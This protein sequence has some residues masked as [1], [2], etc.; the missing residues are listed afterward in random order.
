MLRIQPAQKNVRSMRP[1]I[2]LALAGGGPLGAIYELGAL[3]AL[4]D[5][6]IGLDLTRLDAYVGV[7]AGSFIAA[8]L[9]NN[10]SPGDMCRLF[11]ADDGH[12]RPDVFLRPAYAEY[13]RSASRLPRVLARSAL[14][15][16][17][18][19]LQL[20]LSAQLAHYGK[21]VPPGIFDNDRI[22]RFLHEAFSQVGRSDHFEEL[23]RK[24]FIVA[25][26]LD[27]GKAVRFGSEEFRDIPISRA[28]QASAALPGLYPPVEYRGRQYVDGA[29][30]RTM[31]ASVALDE[32]VSLLIG[33]NPLVPFS[34]EGGVRSLASR[35]LPTVL[36]QTFRAMIHSRMQIGVESYQA[37]YPAADL[38]L[39]EPDRSD[40]RLFFANVFSYSSRQELC[41]HAY[42]VT[43]ADLRRQADA[44]EPILERHG[45]ALNKTHL[46]DPARTFATGLATRTRN[47]SAVGEALARIISNLESDLRAAR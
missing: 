24:L 37:G 6:T 21:L 39:L 18:N 25:V 44:L 45:V 17:R 29:L 3:R 40:E 20:S 26:D 47:A 28:V 1:A 5:C 35:G 33:I 8:S 19:P 14:E 43:R 34:G 15:L 36:S 4:E 42:Q 23:G 16:L 7:S 27:S 12:A 38:C 22:G 2:G 11:I 31:H 30:R 32:G 41:E 9:A 13:L 10:M 46:E